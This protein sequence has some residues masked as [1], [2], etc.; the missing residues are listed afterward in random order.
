MQKIKLSYSRISE[1]DRVGSKSLIERVREDT[2]AT[3]TGSLINDLL[4]KQVDMKE[5]YFIKEYA[6]P[7]SSTLKLANIIVDNYTEIPDDE[8]I[9]NI[10]RKN[11]LWSNTK[12]VEKLKEYYDKPEF[13]EYLTLRMTSTDKLVVDPQ[14]L[15]LGEEIVYVL[16][17]HKYSRNFFN[18]RYRLIPEV[19]FEYEEDVFLLRGIVDMIVLDDENKTFRIVDLKTGAK[20]HTNFNKSVLDWRYYL[21]EAVYMRASDIIK[22]QLGVSDYTTLPFQFLYIGLYEKLPVVF[23]IS[24]VWHNAGLYGF[25]TGSGYRYKG[26]IEL[27]NEIKTLHHHKSYDVPFELFKGEGVLPL[28]S[29]IHV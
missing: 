12:K 8:E 17:T 26:L 6:N 5:K 29:N 23:E 7:T 22:K 1:Y 27:L 20:D 3:T 25:T 18:G 21:Q 11:E 24:D 2:N 4:F 15:T 13:W 16:E 19:S 28:S 9:V 14:M 10:I